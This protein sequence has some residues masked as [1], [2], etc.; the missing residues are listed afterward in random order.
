MDDNTS[1]SGDLAFLKVCP[2]RFF[3]C[4]IAE[5]N[6]VGTAIGL[7]AH[8]KIPFCPRSAASLHALTISCEWPP[9]AAQIS[10]WLARM[11]AF[12]SVRTDHR[13]WGLKTLP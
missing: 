2:D 6:M 9:L 1:V 8:G 5:Q 12:L 10:S 3:E 7:A 4:F 13:K 11:P